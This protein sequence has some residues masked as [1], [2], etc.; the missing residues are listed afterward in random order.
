MCIGSFCTPPEFH[1]G[2][3]D[4]G[5]TDVDCG[6]KNCLKCDTNQHCVTA[7]DCMSQVC[8]GADAGSTGLCAAP[9]CYDNLKNAKETDVDCGGGTPCPQCAQGKGCMAS[10]DCLTE[11]CNKVYPWAPGTCQVASDGG[12]SGSGGGGGGGSC[13]NGGGGSSGAGIVPNWYEG[14][15]PAAEADNCGPYQIMVFE[16]C[17]P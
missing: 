1:D 9:S 15:S 17:F 8:N 6:G 10:T 14:T 12:T 13:S 3:A 11:C 2:I 16:T 5:E 4:A 7:L